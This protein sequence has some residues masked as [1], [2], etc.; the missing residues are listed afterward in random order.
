[1]RASHY[2]E[3]FM[4]WCIAMFALVSVG[5]TGAE[6]RST[7]A[8]PGL[9]QPARRAGPDIPSNTPGL[10]V[11]NE[12]FVDTYMWTEDGGVVYAPDRD[13]AVVRVDS[14]GRRRWML[15]RVGD[16]PG[17]F[18]SIHSVFPLPH[19]SIGVWDGIQR[20]I[21]VIDGNGKPAYTRLLDKWPINADLQIAGRLDDGRYVGRMHRTPID[22]RKGVTDLTDTAVVLVGAFDVEPQRWLTL[23]FEP[24]VLVTDD[25]KRSVNTVTLDRARPA[26]ITVCSRGILVTRD[27]VTERYDRTLHLVQQRPSFAPRRPRESRDSVAFWFRDVKDARVRSEAIDRMAVH[28]NTPADIIL[29]PKVDAHGY[30][31]YARTGTRNVFD[32]Y[33]PAGTKVAE[34]VSLNGP[35]VRGIG[36]A[37][38]ALGLHESDTLSARFAFYRPTTP[39]TF[40]A[41]D[42]TLGFCG[43]TLN[44]Y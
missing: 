31:W 1:M 33:T 21:T 23:L 7:D 2:Q 28:L 29:E 5:C 36:F 17:E 30:L 34:A 38:F 39:I 26:T 4:K 14:L 22:V 11:L 9:P 8:A 6:P 37:R 13:R 19:D 44:G 18:R 42:T 24:M 25:P 20:R 12:D 40:S 10:T 35:I 3:W 41:R 15:D 43:P 32:G 27:T 16:G